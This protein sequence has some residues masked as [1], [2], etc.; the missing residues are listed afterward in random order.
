MYRHFKNGFYVNDKGKV[1]RVR[2][3]KVVKVPIYSNKYGYKY[4]ILFNTTDKEK[5]YIHRAVA[6]L[7]IPN[8]DKSRYVVD[9]INHNKTDNRASNLR[10][11]NY[12]ENIIHK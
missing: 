4:F 2:N 12:S 3:E 10:W 1:K 9:H 6:K 8:N 5:V 11:V 7:F